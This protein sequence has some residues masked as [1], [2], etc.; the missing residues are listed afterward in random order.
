MAVDTD[1]WILL[2]ISTTVLEFDD[3]SMCAIYSIGMHIDAIVYMSRRI[4]D[5]PC[6]YTINMCY[7]VIIGLAV[8][9]FFAA[10]ISGS[11][12]YKEKKSGLFHKPK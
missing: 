6:V 9:A 12:R 1:V 4:I 8:I 10:A 2:D 11:E 5:L 7:G 3:R